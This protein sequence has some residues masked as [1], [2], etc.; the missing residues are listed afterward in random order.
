MRHRLDIDGADIRLDGRPTKLIG[1][2]CSNALIS[3]A[4]ND[5]LVDNLAT[6]AAFGVNTVSVF[7]QG[8]RFGDVAGYLP[9]ASLSED[10]TARLRKIVDAADSQRMVVVV[11]CLYWGNSRAKEALGGWTQEDANRAVA[12]TVAWISSHGYRNVIVDPDNEGMSPFDVGPMIDAGHAVDADCLIGYNDKAPPP[13][14][15]DLYMHFSEKV[16]GTPWVESEGTPTNAPGRYWGEWSKE[17]GY[18]N[19]I[20]IGRYTDEMKANEIENS[21]RDIDRWN[22]YVKACTWLQCGPGEGVG[23]P[24]MTPGGLA[25]E[26][27]APD[28]PKI[29][30]PDAG[31]RWWLDWVHDRYGAW[32]PAD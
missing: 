24:F 12:N 5:S 23:G 25:E 18:Y 27:N 29:L 26:G 2:R 19:Y 7:V 16:D 21:T 22:G 14:N 4:A 9:Y 8:S 17:D 30:Q 10:H 6:F 32:S 1:L 28:D 13:D 3:D 20:R 31:I 11:G 15:A